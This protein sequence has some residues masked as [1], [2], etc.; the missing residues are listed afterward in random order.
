MR[1]LRDK[2]HVQEN[3]MRE[4]LADLLERNYGF[5]MDKA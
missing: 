4:P 2:K 5:G 1:S 3:L